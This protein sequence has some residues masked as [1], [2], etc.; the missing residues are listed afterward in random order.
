MELRKYRPIYEIYIIKEQ[1]KTP[2]RVEISLILSYVIVIVNP[3]V[4]LDKGCHFRMV[5][6]FILLT[7]KH[8]FLTRYKA[9]FDVTI[10]Q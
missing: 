1:Y 5:Y 9:A 2:L 7:Y 6:E 8:E 10:L 4:L 3:T